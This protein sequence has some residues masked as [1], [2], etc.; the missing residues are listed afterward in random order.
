M[1]YKPK[2]M[3]KVQLQNM[4]NIKSLINHSYKICMILIK[5][6]KMSTK[7]KITYQRYLYLMQISILNNY[8]HAKF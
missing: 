5:S 6:D 1:K 4:G 7:K 8:K 2:I 3:G